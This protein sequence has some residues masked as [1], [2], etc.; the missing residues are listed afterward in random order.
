MQ[1]HWVR[2]SL[3]ISLDGR[4]TGPKGGPAF[5][6]GDSDRK[7]LEKSLAWS[8]GALIGGETLRAYK[9]MCL[10]NDPRLIISPLIIIL[11]NRFLFFNKKYPKMVLL[12]AT[13][14]M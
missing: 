4:I 14:D 9:S 7:I 3:A 10:I 11:I 12:R 1:Q 8:D 2:L 13:A 6:G 5:L